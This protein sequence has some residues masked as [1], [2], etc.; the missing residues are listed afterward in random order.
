MGA[1]YALGPSLAAISLVLGK[2]SKEAPF[3]STVKTTGHHQR[4]KD[5]PF[6]SKS[7]GEQPG[8]NLALATLPI[9]HFLC[10]LAHGLYKMKVC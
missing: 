1:G 3:Q 10:L 4:Q 5:F 8:A 2:T 7:Q 9:H 6:P